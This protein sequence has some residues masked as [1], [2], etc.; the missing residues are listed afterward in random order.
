[1]RLIFNRWNSTALQ[2]DALTTNNLTKHYKQLVSRCFVQICK[3]HTSIIR[4]ARR[5]V[6]LEARIN[7]FDHLYNSRTIFRVKNLTE[8]THGFWYQNKLWTTWRELSGVTLSQRLINNKYQCIKFHTD[9]II[10]FHQRMILTNTPSL[11]C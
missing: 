1:M 4:A 9:Y 11:M 3:H 7:Q 10:L 8:P 6:A 2:H 5:A